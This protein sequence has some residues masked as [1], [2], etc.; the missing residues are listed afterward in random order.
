MPSPRSTPP[1]SLLAAPV[2][3]RTLVLPFLV[4]LRAGV[5]VGKEHDADRCDADEDDRYPV[6]DAE[7]LAEHGETD[8]RGHGRL[9]TEK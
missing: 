4:R 1:R 6:D 2:P 3:S 9:C 5:G 8:Q 7:L